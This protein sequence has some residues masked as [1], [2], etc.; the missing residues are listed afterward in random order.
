M[1]IKIL[2]SQPH[3]IPEYLKYISDITHELISYETDISPDK[4]EWIII[5][6]QIKATS[7][8]IKTMPNLRYIFR[9]GVW[10]DNID[11][12]YCKNNN[13]KVVNTPWANADAVADIVLWAILSLSRK[14]NIHKYNRQHRYD[15]EWNQI[16]SQTIGIVWFGNIGKK[17]H[18]RLLAFGAQKF[19][20]YDPFLSAKIVSKYTW[21]IYID[22]LDNLTLQADIITLHLPLTT[23]TYHIIS[24]GSLA[25]AKPNLK[26]INTSRGG[27]IDEKALYK[28]LSANIWAWAMIDVW[29]SEPSFDWIVNDLMKLPNFILTPHIWAM[30]TEATKNM[31]YFSELD[32]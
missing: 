10:L 7:D 2:E 6:V 23:D 26:L 16:T 17:I 3:I 28:F 31:H 20:I 19:L 18:K 8:F 27:I 1:I 21:C 4:I 32:G 12:A 15:Y 5:R 25:N 11:L 22:K 30:T 9:V 24:S 14:T 13:I 29:E